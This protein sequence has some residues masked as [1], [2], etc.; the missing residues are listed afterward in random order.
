MILKLTSEMM[1]TLILKSKIL[2]ESKI[3]LSI[4]VKKCTKLLVFT[5]ETNYETNF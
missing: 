1:M 5:R 3:M 2:V 4:R